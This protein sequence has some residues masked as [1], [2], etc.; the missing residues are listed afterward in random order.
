MLLCACSTRDHASH[1][2]LAIAVS[3][4]SRQY[5]I[6]ISPNIGTAVVIYPIVKRQNHV[7]ALGYVTARIVE[8]TFTSTPRSAT[9]GVSSPSQF[10]SWTRR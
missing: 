10:T 2:S 5:H 6:S 1:A 9:G 8:R 7:L 3:A 4:C